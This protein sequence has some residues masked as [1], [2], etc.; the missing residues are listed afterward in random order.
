M[1]IKKLFATILTGAVFLFGVWV[2]TRVDIAK[3]YLSN[4]TEAQATALAI[5]YGLAS[6][7][8][9]VIMVWLAMVVICPPSI[10]DTK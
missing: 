8:A 6:I 4:L 5:G 9:V 1:A 7:I 10:K 2:V 3:A